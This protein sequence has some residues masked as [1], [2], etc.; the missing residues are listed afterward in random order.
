[1]KIKILK[2]KKIT[3]S[4]GSLIPV[5]LNKFSKFKIKRFFILYGNKNNLRGDHA[6][7]KCTQIF[8]VISGKIEL[9]IINKKKKKKF[10]LN[11]NKKLALL[12][13]P[14]NWC[15]IKFLENNSEVL[16]LCDYKF[17]EKEYIRKFE[18]FLKY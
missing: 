10:I 2:L 1:M 9:E 15:K 7:K 13:S 18:E 5:D 8:I 4:N 12:V 3:N 11:K 14:L 16:V 6:H 17:L